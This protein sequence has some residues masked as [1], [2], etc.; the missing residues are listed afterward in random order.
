MTSR[1]CAEVGTMNPNRLLRVKVSA[2]RAK[3]AEELSKEYG[4]GELDQQSRLYV[5]AVAR[6]EMESGRPTEWMHRH[7]Q[8]LMARQAAIDAM[9]TTI[10]DPDGIR[11]LSDVER[12]ADEQRSHQRHPNGDSVPTTSLAAYVAS[13][14]NSLPDDPNDRGQA[15][16]QRMFW[17][18][19]STCMNGSMRPVGEHLFNMYATTTQAMGNMTALITENRTPMDRAALPAYIE[20]IWASAMS[21]TLY[22]QGIREAGEAPW[23]TRLLTQGGEAVGV[24]TEGVMKMD[25]PL[26]RTQVNLLLHTVEMHPHWGGCMNGAQCAFNVPTGAGSCVEVS[27]SA[28]RVPVVGYL[29]A[30]EISGQKP[31]PAQ[32]RPCIRCILMMLAFAN[33]E[34]I[35]VG[36]LTPAFVTTICFEKGSGPDQ[37]PPDIFFQEV[38]PGN[39]VQTGLS[40]V[41]NVDRIAFTPTTSTIM[42]I[43]YHHTE[44]QVGGNFPAARSCV[45]A[46]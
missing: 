17:R 21:N 31:L 4:N 35:R 27:Y 20:Q 15:E 41:I 40:Q 26:T 11:A 18:R 24:K 10:A 6:A 23:V 25:T 32:P 22:L 12:E 30:E 39:A 46:Q 8:E 19:L 5:P 44:I 43:T 37:F 28:P 29:T 33:A 13:R 7:T 1:V 38:E 3:A 34:S 9:T 2:L 42:G 14:Y 16:F 36:Y 45:T